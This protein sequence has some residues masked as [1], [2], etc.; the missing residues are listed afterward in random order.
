MLTQTILA[1]V[2]RKFHHLSNADFVNCN[3]MAAASHPNFYGVRLLAQTAE[4]QSIQRRDTPKLDI[5]SLLKAA[6]FQ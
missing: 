6:I 5:L 4:V 3:L 1:T 2:Y